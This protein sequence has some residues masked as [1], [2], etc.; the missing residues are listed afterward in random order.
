[1][2]QSMECIDTKLARLRKMHAGSLLWLANQIQ[3]KSSPETAGLT[4][5]KSAK[6]AAPTEDGAAPVRACYL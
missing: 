3:F 6:P 2:P 5:S 1:M 4:F